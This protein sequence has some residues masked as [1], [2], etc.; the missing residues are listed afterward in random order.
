[1]SSSGDMR[2]KYEYKVYSPF[3]AYIKTWTDVANDPSFRT[4]INGGS[5]ELTCKLARQTISFGEE[6]DVNFMNEVQLWA[7]D[8]DEH[9]GIKIF[10][11]YISRY[12][13]INDGGIEYVVVHILGYHTRMSAFVHED[14]LGTTGIAY[15]STDP[16]TIA[17][18]VINKA[19]LNGSPIGWEESTLQKTGTTVSYT[20]QANTM[21]ECIDKILEL[22]PAGWYW[23]VDPDKNLHLHPKSELATHTFTMGKEI[24]Y[25][26]PQKRIENV[27][28]RIYFIGGVPDGETQALYGRYERPLSIN[29]YGMQAIKK[30]DE[31]VK[32]QSTMD[33]I[34]NNILDTQNEVEIRTVIRVK[35]NDY[36]PENGYDIE[37]IKVGD[38]CQIR[39]YG[40]AFI[41]SK[42]DVMY[43]D[44]DSWDFNIRNITETIMQIVEIQYTPN[45]VEL[46]ISSKIPNVAKRVE[47]INRNLVDS[48]AQTAPANPILG[49]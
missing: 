21:Q 1:M 28:N 23:Y 46:T 15:N 9:A 19:S 17:E 47:D 24:F 44:I 8:N 14:S 3:G 33:T 45:W 12:E 18:D 39:N 20:F 48:I 40:E 25:M 30:T 7:F 27:I 41:S 31:R 11:G 2:K 6:N 36:D 16:G 42:W 4:V 43:W 5:V 34:C 29:R 35:D 37:S 13:P 10:S 26:Q 22:T 32:L 49:S 38:T